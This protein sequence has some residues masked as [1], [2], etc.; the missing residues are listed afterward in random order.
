MSNSFKT[1]LASFGV[2]AV[3]LFNT[4]I[5]FANTFN[6][7]AEDAWYSD[8]V[9]QLA[10]EGIVDPG[11]VYR[12]DDALTRAE[13]AEMVIKA[14]DGLAGFEAPATPTFLDVP[15][16]SPYYNYVEAAFALGIVGGYTDANGDRTGVFGPEDSITRAATAKILTSAFDIPVDTGYESIFPDVVEGAWFHDY[17]V[18]AYNQS[19]IDGY[20]NGYFGPGD[21]V[22]RAQIA[23]LIVNSQNPVERAG[24]MKSAASETASVA[25]G[26]LMVSLSPYQPPALT[27][28]RA[29]AAPLL[30]LDFTA[31]NSD[32]VI[33]QITLT[34]GGVGLPSDWAGIYL[35]QGDFK[36][37]S[38]YSVGKSSNKVIIPVD[39]FVGTGTTVTIAAYGDTAVASV[40]LDQH[41]FYLESASDITSDAQSVMGDFPVSGN[42]V[43]IGSQYA[44][45]LLIVPGT[46]P[47]SPERDQHSEIASFKLTAGNSSDVAVKALAL[48]QGGSFATTKMTDCSLLR[49]NDVVATA[50]GFYGEKLIFVPETP[51]IIPEGQSRNFYVKCYIDGGRTTDTIQ[52]Y[53]DQIYDLVTT[54]TDYGFA[55]APL[56]YYSHTLTP[57]LNLQ[58]VKIIIQ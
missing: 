7:V 55:A 46:T 16:D 5:V 6:D 13:L 8:F 17:I 37:T 1:A 45:T 43:T 34:R 23:K 36:I 2:L 20:D 54:D 53:L 52:L 40:P 51:F 14:V 39:I 49:S 42:P 44:N 26:D 27:V 57:S 9:E 3:I 10:E 19:I 18:S 58:G 25:S 31:G 32:V 11:D 41:I 48:T 33:S 28:P 4:S 21:P 15:V 38:E 47:V 56:N 50:A 12:P 35:Y 22:T 24:A 29:S 30:V